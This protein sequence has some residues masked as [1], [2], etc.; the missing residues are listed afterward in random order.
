MLVLAAAVVVVLTWLA[1]RLFVYFLLGIFW[2]YLGCIGQVLWDIWGDIF[3]FGDVISKN[4]PP[5]VYIEEHYTGRLIFEA[6]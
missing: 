6:P 2:A 5:E 4:R 1:S 3:G